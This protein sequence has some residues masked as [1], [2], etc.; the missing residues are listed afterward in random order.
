MY[1]G[2]HKKYLLLLYCFNQNWKSPSTQ[3]HENLVRDKLFH[4]ESL[5]T[6]QDEGNTTA[7][8][9]K[10]VTKTPA[11]QRH[12]IQSQAHDL[13]PVTLQTYG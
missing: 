9:H 10:C 6:G 1:L 13:L 12:L 11:S 2:L 7:S 4:S 5:M 8:F 3:F